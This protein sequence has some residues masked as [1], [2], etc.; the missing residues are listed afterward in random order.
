VSKV[1][2]RLQ[3]HVLADGERVI[4]D[5][6][7]SRG[8]ILVDAE[9]SQELVDFH[10]FIASLPLG[11]NHPSVVEDEAYQTK[12]HQA[13]QYRVAIP[14]IYHSYYADFVEVF[15]STL[16]IEFQSHLFFI[17]GGSVAVENALKTAMDYKIRRN[18]DRDIHG[19]GYQVL[20]LR[21]AF[22]GRTGYCLSVTNTND[23]RKYAHFAK[24]DWPRVDVPALYF[25]R[26]GTAH[27]D[28]IGEEQALQAMRSAL[29]QTRVHDICAILLE[30]I[31]GEGGDRHLSG[32]FLQE[33]YGLSREFDCLVIFDEVQ[34]GFGT[35]GKWWAFEH[36]PIAP[37]LVA[38]GKKTQVCGI[39]ATQH[40]DTVNNTFTTPS[41]I[42]STWGGQLVDM[43]RCEKIIQVIRAEHLLPQIAQQ[44]AYI[45]AQLRE[46]GQQTGLVANVRGRGAFIGFD[47]VDT[48]TR[49]R[50][51]ELS[52]QAGC[53]F[54]TCGEV[55]LRFRPALTIQIWEID[56]GLGILFKVLRQTAR[57]WAAK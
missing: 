45:L 21:N 47:V 10:G 26:A 31:Q 14:D 40:I 17:D 3:K 34:C 22:H 18:F 53:L 54:L 42:S 48:P 8:S 38:F 19:K 29:S 39:A 44:G 35:T 36:Q 4:V 51:R 57:P 5:L 7:R 43:V 12:L 33:V 16:P 24:F 15:A 25:D 56:R 32:E 30:T 6:E 55:S 9:T 28:A 41:R 23:P 11:Y 49:D 27:R 46:F 52:K 20:H 50:V 37:D 13:S 1:V 2:E